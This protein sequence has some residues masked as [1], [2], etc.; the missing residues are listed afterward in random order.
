MTNKEAIENT[1]KV[2]VIKN[3]DYSVV[4]VYQKDI[5][6]F[7]QFFETKEEA[8]K[9]AEEYKQ[10]E[11]NEKKKIEEL[12][13]TMTNAEAIKDIKNLVETLDDYAFYTEEDKVAFYLAIKA[14]EFREK[15]ETLV[16]NKKPD[17]VGVSF[18][19]IEHLLGGGQIAITNQR[20]EVEKEEQK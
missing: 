6:L 16:A 3:G 19:L 17:K 14:L 11:K 1:D 2:W 7:T 10:A 5:G 20:S 12:K 4:E 18:P 8:E 13:G 15:I 9:I